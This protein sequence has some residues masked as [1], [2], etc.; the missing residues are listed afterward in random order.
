MVRL[1]RRWIPGAMAGSEEQTISE[2]LPLLQPL[3]L[4]DSFLVRESGRARR[5]SIHVHPHGQVEVVVPKRTRSADVQSFVVNHRAWIEK[6]RR[7][8]GVDNMPSVALFPTEV[9]FQF[10]DMAW[11]ITRVPAKSRVRLRQSRGELQL[12]GAPG[13][14]LKAFLALQNWIKEQGK[15]HLV[16]RLEALS[17]ETGLKFLRSQIRLQRSRWGSCSSRGSISLNAAALFVEPALVDYLILHELSHT[18]HMNHSARFWKLVDSLSPGARNS[19]R[20]LN[21]AWR[22]VPAWLYRR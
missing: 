15:L 6:A 11:T 8:M 21:R 20:A 9:R 13:D 10:V 17:N 2:Q 3:E 5:M 1:P 12:H 4:T 14:E 16:P 22:D 7:S 18:R 19:D